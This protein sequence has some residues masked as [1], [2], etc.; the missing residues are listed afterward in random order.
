ML[1]FA[2]FVMS[3]V[4]NMDLG[5]LAQLWLQTGNQKPCMTIGSQSSA[6]AAI[7]LVKERQHALDFK[8][9]F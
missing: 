6:E 7:S 9:L 1:R 8:Y 2:Q 4:Q 3:K 5:A